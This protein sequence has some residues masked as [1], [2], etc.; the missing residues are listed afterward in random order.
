M[1]LC[2]D[3]SSSKHIA[4]RNVRDIMQVWTR[5]EP[6]RVDPRR[7]KHRPKLA[8]TSLLHSSVW[9][10]SRWQAHAKPLGR[11]PAESSPGG[12]RC[13]Q[14]AS[15]RHTPNAVL[16][17]DTQLS[18]QR[19]IITCRASETEIDLLRIL[20]PRRICGRHAGAAECSSSGIHCC[21][22]SSR[23]DCPYYARVPRLRP[24]H[25]CRTQLRIQHFQVCL[26]AQRGARGAS[27]LH[28]HAAGMRTLACGKIE[29][30]MRILAP[31]G[32]RA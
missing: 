16:Q 23:S 7:P 10:P 19:A 15:T 2:R 12:R 29:A 24:A 1:P 9:R 25:C 13:V 32:I 28:C 3:S 27:I 5:E 17:N 14:S 26:E 30:L 18:G 6:P 31:E 11:R 21:A 4:R 22:N 20:A 8:G